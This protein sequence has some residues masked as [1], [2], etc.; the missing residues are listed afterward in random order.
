MIYD[1]H[2]GRQFADGGLE[3]QQLMFAEFTPQLADRYIERFGNG[4]ERVDFRP[5]A[6]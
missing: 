2:H 4:F 6:R 3:L 1:T 5:T